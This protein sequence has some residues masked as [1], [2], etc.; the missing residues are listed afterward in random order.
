MT[1]SRIQRGGPLPYTEI[2]QFMSELRA[3]KDRGADALELPDPRPLA[4]AKSSA[5]RGTKSILT[6]GH[7]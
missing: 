1:E 6:G 4:R 2:G 7:G 3:R 5:L